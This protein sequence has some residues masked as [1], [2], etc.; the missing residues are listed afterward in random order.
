[1]RSYT[2]QKIILIHKPIFSRAQF[3]TSRPKSHTTHQVIKGA[4]NF[5]H[6]ESYALLKQS[7]NRCFLYVRHVL[8]LNRY[9]FYFLMLSPKLTLKLKLCTAV[10]E[11]ASGN[12]AMCKILRAVL[13]GLENKLISTTRSTWNCCWQLA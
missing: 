11:G 13:N 12:E 6:C 5:I 1:M 2:P 4:R 10:V 8:F 3:T 7:E 9:G